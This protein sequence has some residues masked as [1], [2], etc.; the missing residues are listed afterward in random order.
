MLI[1][2][3]RKYGTFNTMLAAKKKVVLIEGENTVR[4]NY[5]LIIDSSSQFHVAGAFTNS[6]SFPWLQDIKPDIILV[7]VVQRTGSVEAIRQIKKGLP[8]V[9]ILVLSINEDSELVFN[10]LKNGAIGYV[11]KVSNRND[12]MGALEETLKG[13]APM[14]TNIAR[15]V[16]RELDV[17]NRAVMGKKE[18]EVLV[19][20]SNGNTQSQIAEKLTISRDEVKFVINQIYRI[21]HTAA[22]AS[23]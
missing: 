13:G 2:G 1:S 9:E 6:D 11:S 12:V 7:D 14:N 3:H 4:E 18:A 10:A 8:K 21:L 19:L 17:H 15:R 23:N 22:D 20:L 5:K 16:I